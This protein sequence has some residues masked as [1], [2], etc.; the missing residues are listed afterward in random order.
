MSQIV[1]KYRHRRESMYGMCM[2]IVGI[3]SWPLVFLGLIAALGS[4]DS[5][6]MAVI[7]V[8]VFYGILI[9]LFLWI[10]AILYRASAYG[11][12][13][14][15]TNSQFPHLYK[16]VEQAAHDL[17]LKSVPE[18][19]IYNS[20]GLLNAFARR[21]LGGNFVFLTSALIDVTD[22][23]QV[24][25]VIGHEVGHHAAGHLRFW[26]NFFRMPGHVI[27]FLGA[28]YSRSREYTCDQLGAY[29]SKDLDASRGALQMLGCGCRRLNTGLNCEAFMDQEKLVPPVSGFIN[30]I[31]RSHPRLT[32]RV[33]A[34]KRVVDRLESA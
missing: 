20:N 22:D 1:R 18:T 12:M 5:A 8:Y 2:L 33:A 16:M 10:S 3:I 21:I 23:K 15:L 4:N 13:I 27:P 7:G 31:F 9:A 34:I 32:R 26:P 17:G 19:F 14:L 24:N 6:T 30:E 29:V 28:A 11:N 25:F